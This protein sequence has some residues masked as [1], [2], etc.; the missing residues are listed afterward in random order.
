MKNT[1][2]IPTALAQFLELRPKLPM[3]AMLPEEEQ[4]LFTLE[5]KYDDWSAA[6]DGCHP[7]LRDRRAHE[8]RQ[9]VNA[10][11]TIEEMKAAVRRA[12]EFSAT[13]EGTYLASRLAVRKIAIE[14]AEVIRP[15]LLRE[16]GKVQAFCATLQG[17][18]LA[19]LDLTCQPLLSQIGGIQSRL[20]FNLAEVSAILVGDDDSTVRPLNLAPALRPAAAKASTQPAALLADSSEFTSWA[21]GSRSVGPADTGAIQKGVALDIGHALGSGNRT[22]A[23]A[24]MASITKGND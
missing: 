19:A 17:L 13:A 14:A 16:L 6:A 1:A 23:C 21:A 20:E 15:A 8:L 24:I 18:D 12:S 2:E 5:K 9:A 22:A 10:A 4:K 7:S 3:P 11:E